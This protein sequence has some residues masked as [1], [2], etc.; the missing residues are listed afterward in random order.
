MVEADIK[1]AKTAFT[2]L[3]DSLPV[4]DLEEIAIIV[5]G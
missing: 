5:S 3:F 2:F 4:L 1:M